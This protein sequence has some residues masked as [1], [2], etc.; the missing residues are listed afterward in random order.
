MRSMEPGPRKAGP[1]NDLKTLGTLLPY[2]WPPGETAL[3]VRV[4]FAMVLLTLAKI[5]N[6]VVPVFYKY[7]VD[8]LN[9]DTTKIV[10]VPVVLL[11][12]Y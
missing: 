5:T 6:V 3:R 9:G 12:A 4:V 1:R 11:I 2:L 7:A 10:A 8:A